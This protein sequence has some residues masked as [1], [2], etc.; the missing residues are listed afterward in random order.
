M[1]FD[2]TI[3][4]TCYYFWGLTKP[5]CHVKGRTI[6]EGECLYYKEVEPEPSELE[7][8]M[9]EYEEYMEEWN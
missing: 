1:K 4:D 8:K 6:Y 9:Q 3:C 7:L 2:R 5:H